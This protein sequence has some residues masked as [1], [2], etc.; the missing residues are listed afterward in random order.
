[1][2]PLCLPLVFGVV[3]GTVG[4]SSDASELTCPLL[5]QQGLG[6]FVVGSPLLQGLGSCVV[7]PLLL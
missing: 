6:D 2:G 7:G 3:L 5:L 1:M 4:H